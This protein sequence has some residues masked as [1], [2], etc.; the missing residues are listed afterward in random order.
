MITAIVI[1]SVLCL[2]SGISK[3]IMDTLQFH[4]E[5]SVFADKSTWWNP[6]KSWQNKYTWAGNS[7]ILGWL[8]QNPLVAVTDAWHLFQAIFSI[9]F[10]SSFVLC[11]AYMPLWS[12]VPAYITHR[13]IFHIFFTWLLVKKQK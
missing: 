3:A 7:K 13:V 12:A 9:T 1:A 4:F 5:K 11:G 2:V 6:Q 8:L 10:A